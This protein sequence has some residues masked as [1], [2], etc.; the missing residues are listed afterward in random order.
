MRQD[1]AW[2]LGQ[3]SERRVL[4]ATWVTETEHGEAATVLLYPAGHGVARQ[5]RVVADLAGLV[6]ADAEQMVS[7]DPQQARVLVGVDGLRV[8]LGEHQ[9]LP[10]PCRPDW[11]AAADRGR[12]VLLVGMDPWSGRD[13]DLDGYLARTRRLRAGLVQVVSD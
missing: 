5:M 3:Q 6:P 12:A 2:L 7:V 11:T 1:V 9:L 8:C 13:A 10:S 4:L